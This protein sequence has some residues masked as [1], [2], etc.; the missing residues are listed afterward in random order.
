M[1]SWKLLGTFG[2]LVPLP[3]VALLAAPATASDHLDTPTAVEEPRGDIGDLYAWMSADGRRLNI[4][5]TITGRQF[6]PQID[7]V[8]HI[9][10]GHK[11][12]Q[13]GA[14]IELG[15][16]IKSPDH[17]DCALGHI[18]RAVGD[19][20]KERGLASRNGSFRL[21]AGPRDDPFFN[22][23]QGTRGMYELAA[24]FL[25][26]GAPE[27]L[28]G[29]PSFGPAA[30][31][32]LM[33]R[34]S[35]TNGTTGKNFLAGWSTAALVV[36]IDVRRISK[37]GE[38]LALWADTTGPVGVIDRTGRP[39]TGNSLFATLGPKSKGDR[40]KEEFNRASPLRARK[41]VR[42]LAEGLALYDGFDGICG[43]Q[44]APIVPQ[45]TD[46]SRYDQLAAL[47]ADD[48][49]WIDSRWRR[50]TSLFAVERFRLSAALAFKED[51]GGRSLNAD[52]ANIFRSLLVDGTET[53]VSDGA[54][55]DDRMHSADTFPFLAAPAPMDPRDRP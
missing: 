26:A 41:F 31:Q 51:C 16:R 10:S 36:S 43:N 2:L 39:L 22:N 33:E 18:D 54:H 40:Q 50:C 6:S 42:E 55:S 35:R 37:G 3:V 13:T 30:S 24:S 7:Y 19:A 11:F 20:R 34:W 9:E 21:F 17:A 8:F 5:M 38:L 52:A 29:C 46:K 1:M 4:V 49:L 28:S 45:E 44:W 48:R 23:V 12:G 14:S 53:R 27:D 47:L 15:C 32:T 25:A